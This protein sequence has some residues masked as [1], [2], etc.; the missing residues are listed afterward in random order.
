MKLTEALSKYKSG[1]QSILL[2]IMVIA[3]ILMFFAIQ[4]GWTV[5]VFIG[6]AAIIL[7]NITASLTK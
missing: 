1:V 3:P 2:I 5:L 4:K 7:A 6:L